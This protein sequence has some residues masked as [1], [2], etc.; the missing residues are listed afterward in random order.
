M[1]NS[2]GTPIY[3]PYGSVPPPRGSYFEYP[4]G[5]NPPAGSSCFR[6]LHTNHE[7]ES[8]VEN[9]ETADP[10][11]VCSTMRYF[12]ESV[13]HHHD[14]HYGILPV[15]MDSEWKELV[16]FCRN[17]SKIERCRDSDKCFRGVNITEV[18]YIQ[19]TNVSC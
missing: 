18:S 2:G 8:M 9:P 5:V 15:P 12:D 19:S 10:N 3:K 17:G 7:F 6:R 4:P 1:V 16:G 11:Y 13:V 14:L